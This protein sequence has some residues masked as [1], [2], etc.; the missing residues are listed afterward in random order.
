MIQLLKKLLLFLSLKRLLGGDHLRL[1]EPACLGVVLGWGHT[2]TSGPLSLPI[3]LVI[4]SIDR[5]MVLIGWVPESLSS[6]PHLLCPLWGPFQ[7][8]HFDA[9]SHIYNVVAISLGIGDHHLWVGCL[10]N[11]TGVYQYLACIQAPFGCFHYAS[12]VIGPLGV[13]HALIWVI[14]SSSFI[15]IVGF[16]AT[17]WEVPLLRWIHTDAML[18]GLSLSQAL[19]AAMLPSFMRWKVVDLIPLSWYRQQ[20]LIFS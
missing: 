1:L 20:A 11:G 18:I 13:D 7:S 15:K 19:R 6:L 14:L 9:G 3:V 4:H 12:S 16:D 5:L 8:S 2:F 17:I 10:I